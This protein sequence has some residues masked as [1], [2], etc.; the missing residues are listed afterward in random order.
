[1]SSAAA[2]RKHHAEESE[3]EPEL[4]E[5]DDDRWDDHDDDDRAFDFDDQT[6]QRNVPGVLVAG[7]GVVRCNWSDAVDDDAHPARKKARV[8]PDEQTAL[9]QLQDAAAVAER[10]QLKGPSWRYGECRAG[11]MWHSAILDAIRTSLVQRLTVLRIDDFPGAGDPIFGTRHEL[12]RRFRAPDLFAG[13]TLAFAGRT[14]CNLKTLTLQGGFMSAE[15]L[16]AFLQVAKPPLESFRC[17]R[18]LFHGRNF[19]AIVGSLRTSIQD[20]G[21]LH[22]FET[23]ACIGG[24]DPFGLIA[25]SFP[26]LRVLRARRIFGKADHRVALQELPQLQRK[27]CRFPKYSH[28][29]RGKPAVGEKGVVYWFITSDYHD[30]GYR[31]QGLFWD[32]LNNTCECME[33]WRVGRGVTQEQCLEFMGECGIDLDDGLDDGDCGMMSG[34]GEEVSEDEQDTIVAQLGVKV[35]SPQEVLIQAATMQGRIFA[36]VSFDPSKTLIRGLIEE[37]ATKYP[38]SSEALRLVLPDNSS[39]DVLGH[40]SKTMA[41]VLG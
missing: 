25:T 35:V 32:E 17:R 14:R 23:D 3:E 11:D 33:E 37:L 21:G 24:Q 6:A 40:G 10:F 12:R 41:S 30:D 18:C 19:E 9:A 5:S 4:G 7:D 1:M 26:K 36:E 20:A 34:P 13:L 15:S 29:L 28:R 2:N 39:V 8:Y 16:M 31:G 27:K 22:E 38:C